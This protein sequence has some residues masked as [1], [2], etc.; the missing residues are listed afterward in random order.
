M[1]KLVL[2]YHWY[3]PYEADGDEIIPF[4]YE[5]KEQAFVDFMELRENTDW[6]FY[7]LGKRFEVGATKDAQFF[8]L[9]EWFERYKLKTR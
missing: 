4:E 5:S 7:F 9:E 1:E 6:E 8:T 3:I 2:R